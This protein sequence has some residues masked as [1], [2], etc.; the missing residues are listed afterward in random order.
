MMLFLFDDEF[1]ESQLVDLTCWGAAEKYAEDMGWS[2][3]GKF[4]MYVDE[5]TGE[6]IY[7]Q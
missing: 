5:E 6:N 3:I 1:G 4:E 2:L 7:I